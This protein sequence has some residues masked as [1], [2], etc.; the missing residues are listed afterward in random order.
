VL[1]ET[2]PGAKAELGANW[3]HGIDQNP[4]F[5]IAREHGLL[6]T[7]YQGRKLG[8]KIMFVQEC[9]S[10]VNTKVVEEVDFAY[11]MLINQCEEFYQEQ[12]PTPVDSV[13]EFLE[14]EFAERMCRYSA[15][16]LQLRQRILRQRMLGECIVGG[17]HSLGEMSLSEIGAFKELPGVHHVIPPGFEAVLNILRSDVPDARIQLNQEVTQITWRRELNDDNHDDNA[18]SATSPTNAANVSPVCIEC[19]NGKRYNADHVIVT[20]SLGVLKKYQTRLFSPPLPNFKTDA[21]NRLT[22]GTVN[23][24]ILEFDG[25]VLPDEVFRLELIWDINNEEIADMKDSWV[26]KIGAFEAVAHNVLI[27]KHFSS[28]YFFK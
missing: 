19:A 6:D 25:Q 11:G 23:K 5:K 3:I 27:G 28:T 10:P 15:R 16:D 17:C 4:I 8:K 18:V 13:G 20:S 2:V 24:V 21:M 7:H 1:A 14:R 26:K 9:G 12:I 22:I